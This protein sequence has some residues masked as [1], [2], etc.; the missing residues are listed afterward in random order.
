LVTWVA[1]LVRENSDHA[2]QWVGWA[3]HLPEGTAKAAAVAQVFDVWARVAP[4]VA[5]RWLNA[6]P[7]SPNVD[8][9]I[10]GYVLGAIAQYLAA[11][12]NAEDLMIWASSIRSP[13]LRARTVSETW[14]AWAEHDAAS[15]ATWARAHDYPF[16][17]SHTAAQ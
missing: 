9:A 17:A 1:G 11:P 16:P 14:Q 2:A 5:G 10:R 15:A 4:D 7:P 13:T 12:G 6:L 3:L 8:N